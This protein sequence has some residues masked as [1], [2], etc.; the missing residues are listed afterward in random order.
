MAYS[1]NVIR[2][3]MGIKKLTPFIVIILIAIISFLSFIGPLV[4]YI[5]SNSLQKVK[6]PQPV[7]SIMAVMGFPKEWLFFPAI[8]Y[9]GIVPFLIL[10][11]S[12]YGVLNDIVKLFNEKLNMILAFLIPITIIPLGFFTRIVSYVLSTWTIFWFGT[13]AVILFLNVIIHFWGRMSGFGFM[14][15]LEDNLNKEKLE[16][17]LIQL[18]NEVTQIIATARSAA[19]ASGDQELAKSVVR[20]LGKFNAANTVGLI[21]AEK[22]NILDLKRAISLLKEARGELG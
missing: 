12:I 6:I 5:P 18:Q 11:V 17:E 20:A 4:L 1:A 7:Y 19:R 22:Q 13:M 16:V 15:E 10:S 21:Y 2:A 8:I 14:E 3:L 9:T